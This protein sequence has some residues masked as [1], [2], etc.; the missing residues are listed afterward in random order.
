L[1]CYK[2]NDRG[3]KKIFILD[4][5]S[6]EYDRQNILKEIKYLVYERKNIF[7]EII[8]DINNLKDSEILYLNINPENHV[9]S[10]T[11]CLEKYYYVEKIRKFSDIK[12]YFDKNEIPKNYKKI[13][14]ENISYFF[15]YKKN[16]NITFE[17]FVKKKRNKIKKEMI[18]FSTFKLKSVLKYIEKKKCLVI[19][20]IYLSIFLQIILI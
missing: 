15:E 13:F 14:G 5:Y 19:M 1:C 4:G 9:N 7:L 3:R 8:Y 17:D 20:M 12:K 18:V 11:K 6:Y 16:K 10:N 2:A